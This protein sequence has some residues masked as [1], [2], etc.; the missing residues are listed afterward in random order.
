MPRIIFALVFSLS[1]MLMLSGCGFLGSSPD[2][3]MA[4]PQAQKAVQAAYSQVG[5]PYRLG[6]ASPRQ[7][8]DCSGL[9]YWAYKSNGVKV[10]RRTSDQ[11]RAGYGVSRDDTLP[12]DIVVFRMG[13]RALHTGMYAGGNSFIHSPRKGSNVRMESLSKPYWSKR[14][15]S[16][17]RVSG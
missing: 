13:A 14:L 5:K 3:G 2:D 10:P 9:I 15:V 1:A 17:R 7:G 16:I 6:G 12:G 8:F 11:I 4:T